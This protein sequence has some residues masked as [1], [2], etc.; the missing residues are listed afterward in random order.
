M[1]IVNTVLVWNFLSSSMSCIWKSYIAS[2]PF[3]D[4]VDRSLKDGVIIL[5]TVCLRV[6]GSICRVPMLVAPS[7]DGC[8]SELW[9]S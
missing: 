8:R 1:V 9:L 3:G 7:K 2:L 6:Y 4:P 5:D